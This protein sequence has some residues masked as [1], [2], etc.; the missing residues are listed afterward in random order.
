MSFVRGKSTISFCTKLFSCINYL[1][2]FKYVTKKVTEYQL[3]LEPISRHL[4]LSIFPEN[5]MR[6]PVS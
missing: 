5:I 4:S 6:P 1:Q 2:L 3:T